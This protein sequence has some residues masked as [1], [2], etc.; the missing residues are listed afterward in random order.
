MLTKVPEL[1]VVLDGELQALV[2][3]EL[4]PVGRVRLEMASRQPDQVRRGCRR[5][6]PMGPLHRLAASLVACPR[7]PSVRTLRVLS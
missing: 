5:L 2:H 3:G 7:R 4:P 1:L 6:T